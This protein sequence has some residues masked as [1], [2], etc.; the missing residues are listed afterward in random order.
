VVLVM[1]ATKPDSDPVSDSETAIVPTRPAAIA[2]RVNRRRL[3]SWWAGGTD[4]V[5][6]FAEDRVRQGDRFVAPDTPA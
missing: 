5:G 1:V 6:P 3:G 2:A 4:T